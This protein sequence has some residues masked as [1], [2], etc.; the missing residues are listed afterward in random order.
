[1]MKKHLT[2]DRHIIYNSYYS[3]N[4]LTVF[5]TV[6]SGQDYIGDETLT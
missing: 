6:Y 3:I 1:M 5:L 4:L 2:I